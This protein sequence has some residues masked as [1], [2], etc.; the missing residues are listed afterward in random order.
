MPAV[1]T[2][3]QLPDE[4][5]V[6]LRYLESTGIVVAMPDHWVKNKEELFPQP[7]RKF[8]AE[9]NPDQLLF[10]LEQQLTNLSFEPREHAGERGFMYP[11]TM[12][13]SV[14]VYSRPKYRDK[15]KLGES[16]LAAYWTC[17]DESRTSIIDKD[18]EFVKWGKKVL[19]WARRHTPEG[20]EYKGDRVTKRAKEAAER[21]IVEL[22]R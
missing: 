17:L 6:F 11:D 2:F 22:V 3:W 8:I 13:I 15:G 5:E 7:I 10:G 4:E 9:H 12:K 14:L 18:P 1:V 21:G 20:H 19:A 16:N